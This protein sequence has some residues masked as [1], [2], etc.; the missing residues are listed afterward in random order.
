M[1]NLIK[2]STYL[3]VPNLKSKFLK[4]NQN[5]SRD[6]LFSFFYYLRCPSIFFLFYFIKSSKFNN[7]TIQIKTNFWKY[8]NNQIK[9]Q[10]LI[11]GAN[12]Q[13]ST[14]TIKLLK[15]CKLNHFITILNI[16]DRHEHIQETRREETFPLTKQVADWGNGCNHNNYNI[17]IIK[18]DSD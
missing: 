5:E 10:N 18:S 14:S 2:Y 4:V 17:I 1:I 6:L 7:I 13:T 9:Y 3:Y 15:V 16:T 8:L 11:K 12:K